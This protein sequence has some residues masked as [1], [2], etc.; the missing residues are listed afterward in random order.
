MSSSY[1]KR[2]SSRHNYLPGLSLLYTCY[3]HDIPLSSDSWNSSLQFPTN[4][5]VW[6]AKRICTP[7]FCIQTENFFSLESFLFYPLS[8]SSLFFFLSSR[9]LWWQ[10][11]LDP[12][13][14]PPQIWQVAAPIGRPC[15][16]VQFKRTCD[17]AI[18]SS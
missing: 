3:P 4:S 11:S 8:F 18:V 7:L 12:D 17:E 6:E 9:P 13:G 1:V 15:F 10:I 2:D 16:W 5:F 14:F